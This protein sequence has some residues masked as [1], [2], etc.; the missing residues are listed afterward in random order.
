[1]AGSGAGSCRAGSYESAD[2]ASVLPSSF[3]L[4][5]ADRVCDLE[6]RILIV[7]DKHVTVVSRP[8]LTRTR[9]PIARQG[10]LGDRC[11]GPGGGHAGCSITFQ[12]FW[13]PVLG[14]GY[15]EFGT[16]AGNMLVPDGDLNQAQGCRE[17]IR[18]RGIATCSTANH[19]VT[20]AYDSPAFGQPRCWH[21][22]ATLWDSPA[23]QH[24]ELDGDV[25][26]AASAGDRWVFRFAAGSAADPAVVLGFDRRAHTATLEVAGQREPCVAFRLSQ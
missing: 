10:S 12:R 14:R 8:R 19:F 5:T 13:S 16:S 3:T 11:A 2:P 4:P 22:H 17:S 24:L 18:G 26:R 25:D 20:I 9:A 15:L 23:T 1:V 6:D 21:L 7:D